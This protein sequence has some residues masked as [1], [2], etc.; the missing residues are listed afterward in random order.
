MPRPQTLLDAVPIIVQR[1]IKPFKNRVNGMIAK[2]VLKAVTETS[3]MR[4]V[5]FEVF[6]DEGEEGEHFEPYGWT[7]RPLD[8]AEAIVVSL[9]GSR[10]K[11]VVITVSDRRHR[12]KDL[13]PGEM[14]IHDDQGARVHLKRDRIVVIPPPGGTVELG[15]GTLKDS[16]RK[17]DAV[18]AVIPA[19]SVVIDVV[20]HAAVKNL[21]DIVLDGQITE[22]STV[23]KASD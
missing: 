23:V 10:D 15:S 4:K 19:G 5:Q 14:C 7:S 22:G 17:T 6:A 2:A 8:G 20:A 3:K 16:A 1:V 18:Q 21:T 11:R 13:E 9:G 12:P